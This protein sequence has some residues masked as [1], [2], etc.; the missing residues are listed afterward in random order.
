MNSKYPP[1][2]CLAAPGGNARARYISRTLAL[3]SSYNSD[4]SRIQECGESLDWWRWWLPPIQPSVPPY[5]CL[6]PSW[7]ESHSHMCRTRPCSYIFKTGGNNLRVLAYQKHHYAFIGTIDHLGLH[8]SG[9][10]LVGGRM[11]SS[12]LA[13]KTY[14]T[15]SRGTGNRSRSM[16]NDETSWIWIWR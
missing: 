3:T 14:P 1:P 7:H 12:L 5:F 2:S 6:W 10:S 15:A 4:P 16:I 13:L 9:Q 11:G 8:S